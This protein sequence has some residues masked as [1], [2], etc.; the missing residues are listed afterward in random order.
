VLPYYQGML[1]LFIALFVAWIV[2]VVVIATVL[3]RS[4]KLKLK[5][6]GA[7]GTSSSGGSDAGII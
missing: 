3:V 5:K 1:T 6:G 7:P 4:G 2:V